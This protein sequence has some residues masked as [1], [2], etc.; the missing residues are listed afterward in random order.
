MAN[1][2]TTAAWVAHELGLASS[3][4][5]LLFGKL[6]LN[7]NLDVIEDKS[8]RG[9]LLNKTWNRYN[10]VNAVS[11]GTAIA[12]W[13]TGR[14]AISGRYALDDE[15]NNLVRAKDAL[16]ATAAVAGLASIIS[17]LSLSR[18]APD[19]ATP[20]DSGVSP[21]PEMSEEA[22]KLLRRVNLLGNVNIAVLGGVIA[23][24]TILSMKANQ[25]LRWSI[26]SRLLP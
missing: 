18:Q 24:S 8:E 5:G 19:G 16:L 20:I 23:V 13:L 6:A 10:A 12:T 4:G 25:S 15:A 9:K 1:K 7:P 2:L 21:A 22:A 26:A 14:S 17:G 3:L 11:V